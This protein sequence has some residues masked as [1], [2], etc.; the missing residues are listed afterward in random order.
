MSNFYWNVGKIP[1]V[2]EILDTPD[3]RFNIPNF[4]P[5]EVF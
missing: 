4:V 3:N 1:F 2:Y 5:F